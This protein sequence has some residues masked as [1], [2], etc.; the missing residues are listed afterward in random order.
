MMINKI[1]RKLLSSW[2]D[3]GDE[4]FPGVAKFE[5]IKL[6]F[7]RLNYS[8]H[9][10]QFVAIAFTLMLAYSENNPSYMAIWLL[11]YIAFSLFARRVYRR[12]DKTRITELNDEYFITW[13]STVRK[14][15]AA[16][17]L[18]LTVGLG[19][20][21]GTNYDIRMLM[22]VT[23]AAITALNATHQT[24]R[25]DVFF[26]FFITGWCLQTLMMPLVFPEQGLFVTPLVFLYLFGM[27]RYAYFAHELF[28]EHIKL[29]ERS[30]TLAENYKVA[31]DSAESLLK[32]KNL[33][34]ATASHDLRQPAHALNLI[35]ASLQQLNKNDDM[36]S[37]LSD[38]RHSAQSLNLMLDSLLDLTRLENGGNVVN[39]YPV[40]LTALLRETQKIFSGLAASRTLDFRIRSPKNMVWVMADPV[41]LRQILANLVHNAIRYSKSGGVL[42]SVRRKGKN[43]LLQVW[44]TGVGLAQQDYENIYNPYFRSDNAWQFDKAG[45]G[46][47]LSV[48][49][50]CAGLMNLPYGFN[51]RSGKG[52][53]FWITLPVS[54]YTP[55]ICIEKSDDYIESL[56]G[57]CLVL[58]DDLHICNAL[59]FLLESWGMQVRSA[60]CGSE[61]MDHL[62]SGFLPD[63][64]LFDQR[65]NSGE[66]GFAI[67]K[68][69]MNKLDFSR[70]IMISG[71]HNSVELSQAEDEGYLVLRK[72]VDTNELYCV[73]SQIKIK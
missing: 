47:G 21:I 12:F 34:L 2:T 57:N 43:W 16:H 59:C 9:A 8:I 64:L 71:E 56:K 7:K 72:P 31:K 37:L 53:C 23:L 11:F 5:L 24:A 48:V 41:M 58:E 60:S 73:F 62:S 26:R 46:L 36:S 65:L 50:R 55:D 32:E 51:S 17:G 22:L 1:F 3:S 67:M 20:T 49:A 10:V 40:S 70:G 42:L 44:D 19:L 6:S 35:A 18:G 27:A 28:V 69:V 61:V 66:S 30:K 14:I 52:T 45:H 33:F 15:S 13:G 25:I 68:S 39:Y 29:Q 54:D 4:E 38:L 63:I